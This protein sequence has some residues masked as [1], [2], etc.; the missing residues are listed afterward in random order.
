MATQ[1]C[2]EVDRESELP[3][4]GLCQSSLIVLPALGIL[5]VF[6]M[7]LFYFG[8]SKPSLVR[9]AV[10]GAWDRLLLS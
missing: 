9:S 1:V 7:G 5:R 8:F 2:P 10:R 4:N 3:G 6:G